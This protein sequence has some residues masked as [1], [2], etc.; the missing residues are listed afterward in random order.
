[1]ATPRRL[2]GCWTVVL[3]GC[4]SVLGPAL[5]RADD[6]AQMRWRTEQYDAYWD[7]GRYQEAARVQEQL[8]AIAERAY[9]NQP[10]KLA[11][12]LNNLAIAYDNLGRHAEA[13]AL[14]Q[15][16]L[17]I[18]ERTFGPNHVQLAMPLN[19]LAILY[20]DEGRYAEAESAC[21]KALDICETTLG[22]EHDW[23]GDCLALLGVLCR[24]QGRQAEAESLL[25]Q[26]LAN[27]EKSLGPDHPEVAVALGRLAGVYLD[28]GRYADAEP[29]VDR[30]IDILGRTRMRPDALPLLYQI[31]SDLRWPTKRTQPAIDDLGRAIE[32][33]I[34]SACQTNYGP[35]QQGEGVW[36]LSRGFLVAGSGRV[37]ASNWLVDDEAA[38]TLMTYFCQYLA[39][40]EKNKRPVD[41]AE[42]LHQAKRAVRQQ[43]KWAGPYYWATFVLV[44]P[45]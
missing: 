35:Q 32:L 26:A 31:R 38:A 30:A 22:A 43:E 17:A 28:Q 34:L 11:V 16:A 25:K 3:A 18:K 15:R 14:Y 29:L 9:R 8:L 39:T 33:A 21:K 12:E 2:A 40:P 10:T 45:N 5:S 19:N 41:Y 20:N 24:D 1:M 36:A 37:V 13:A 23:T 42:A 44:G 7:A 27:L 4:V 6:A